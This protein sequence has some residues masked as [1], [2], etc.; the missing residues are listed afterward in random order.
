MLDRIKQ[1]FN[2]RQS[3]PFEHLAS[4][5][6]SKAEEE[7]KRAEM[8]CYRAHLAYENAQADYKAKIYGAKKRME[9]AENEYSQAQAY[10][11]GIK[12]FVEWSVPEDIWMGWRE[13]CLRKHVS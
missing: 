6:M 1:F 3:I 11:N 13:E 4:M 2:R 7:Y 10:F 9:K 12:F 8:V 5:P